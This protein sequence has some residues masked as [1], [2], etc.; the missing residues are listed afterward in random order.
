MI[1]I[2]VCIVFACLF[3]TQLRELPS[4]ALGWFIFLAAI[5]FTFRQTRLLAILLIATCYSLFI[6]EHRLNQRLSS[7]LIGQDIQLSGQVGSIPKFQGRRIQFDFI[8]DQHPSYPLPK[9]LLL[10]WY[11]PF[12]D[13]LRSGQRW[14]F[15][16]RL[17]PPHGLANPGGFDYEAWLFEHGIGGTGYIR[18]TAQQIKLSDAPNWYIDSL[19]H[20]ILDHL[21]IQFD[22][23]TNLGMLQALTTG[24]RHNISQPQW[25]LL[26]QTGTSHLIA[27]SGL[28][29]GLVAALGFFVSCFFWSLRANN[30]LAIPANSF[31]AIAGLLFATLYALLAGL[32]IPTQRAL[33]MVA[34]VTL[35]ITIK[36]PTR[37]SDVLA[38]AVILILILEPLSVLSAG[39]WLSCFAVAI[40]LLY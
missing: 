19:R 9:K 3:I 22:L 16:V 27:I 26:Q 40:I 30:L 4:L 20:R 31:A 5:L 39:F 10:N 23:Q 33:I 15:T 6:A 2:A 38:C 8:P 12:P 18:P 36:R 37:I 32:S 24:I 11:Q 1:K 7:E 29:I 17:K 25:Q 34:A 14:Q 28:H 21:D 13:D 35:S